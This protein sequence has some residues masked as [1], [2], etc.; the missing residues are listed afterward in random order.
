MSLRG[1]LVCAAREIDRVTYG[2]QGQPLIHIDQMEERCR[3]IV[4]KL[5]WT[6]ADTP[7]VL[8]MAAKQAERFH[9]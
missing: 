9:G 8:T 3:A 2:T 4:A 5:T 7:D 6:S 1:L